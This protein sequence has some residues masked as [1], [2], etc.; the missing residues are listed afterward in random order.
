MPGKHIITDISM[1]YDDLSRELTQELSKDIKKNNGI[2]FTPPATI[3]K[4]LD[5]LKPYFKKITNILEPSCG[6]GEYINAIHKI[7]PHIDITAIEYNQTIYNSI[8]HLS[9]DR[10][11]IKHRDFLKYNDDKKYEL[12]IGNPPYFVMKKIDIDEQYHKFFDGRPNIFVIFI[13]K[14][15]EMLAVNGILSFILPK[16]FTNCLYYEKTRKYIVDNFKIL[17]I[18]NCNDRYIETQQETIIIII[19]NKN[20]RNKKNNNKFIININDS[21]VFA[22]ENN[23]K[24]LQKIYEGSTSLNKLGFKVNVGNV[25]WNQCKKILTDDKN[26]TR[27]IYSS[28]ITDNTFSPKKYKNKDKK[29]FIDKPGI[30]EPVLIVNRGYGVGEY[31]LNYCLIDGSF[32]YLI[33][34]HLICI[35]YKEPINSDML[36]SKYNKIIESLQDPRTKTFISVYFGN[37]AINTTELNNIFPIFGF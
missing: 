37:N 27:L 24:L 14:S 6:S 25:V 21:I 31:K 9:N 3:Y 22:S 15:L 4:N 19:Q 32:K 7:Y 16:S 11:T 10:I 13:I 29:N 2:F 30:S 33:E 12:I 8:K 28:D 5:Y 20:Q 34:N 23:I 1:E 18:I 17:N 36:T 26:K 35:K